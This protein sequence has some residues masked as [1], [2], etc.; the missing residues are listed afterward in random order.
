[1]LRARGRERRGERGEQ[2]EPCSLLE[3]SVEVEEKSSRASSLRGEVE[4]RKA[5]RREA[6]VRAHSVR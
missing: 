2:E 1:M 6:R 4:K 5:G 3:G